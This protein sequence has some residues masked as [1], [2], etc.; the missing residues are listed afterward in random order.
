MKLFAAI[1][2][3]FVISSVPAN[4]NNFQKGEE[5]MEQG[6][7]QAALMVWQPLADSGHAPSQNRVASLFSEGICYPQD[8]PAA[9]KGYR[10]S[11][12]QDFTPAQVSLG[13]LYEKGLGVPKDIGKAKKWYK[14]AAALGD[15]QATTKLENLK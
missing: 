5:A 13:E 9:A 1:L 15:T 12:D 3:V 7:F 2:A 6:D 10:K 11:A 8:Y 4:A 14:R